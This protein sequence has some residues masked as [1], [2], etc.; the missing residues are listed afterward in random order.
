MFYAQSSAKAHIRAKLNVFLQV[1]IL[2]DYSIHIPPLMTEE[3]WRK[4]KLNEPGR[5]LLDR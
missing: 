1:N 2:T 3:I 5:Q 4:M